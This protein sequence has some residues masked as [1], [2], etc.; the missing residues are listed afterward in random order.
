MLF[1]STVSMIKERLFRG[2]R[3]VLVLL[4]LAVCGTTA[5]AQQNLPRVVFLPLENLAGEQYERD[6]RTIGELLASFINETRRVNVI[7]RMAL[8]AAMAARRFRVEDWENISKTA[9]MGRALNATYIVRGSVSLLGENLIVSARL[10]DIAS[11]ET[12]SFINMQLEALS[13]AYFKMN[14][15]AQL[16][17]NNLE[18]PE[19]PPSAPPPV[20]KE[21]PPVPPPPSEEPPPIAEEASPVPLPL[22]EL[23]APDAGRVAR[24]NTLGVST[25]TVV[26]DPLIII[27]VRGTFAPL[28][29][30]FLEAGCDFGFLSRN[31]KVVKYFSAYP[32]V[33]AEFFLPFA[34]T[35]GAITSGW[36]IG[37][38]GGYMFGKY[39]SYNSY[40]SYDENTGEYTGVPTETLLGIFTADFITGF[41]FAGFC[42]I[43]YTL[44]TDFASVSSK[45]SIGYTYRFK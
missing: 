15:L 34:D 17:T 7:D 28:R 39:T 21:L 36:Y 3:T 43:S 41:N 32:F 4:L 19:Q 9:E 24:L 1:D 11:T 27:T 6:V 2:K 23:A 18:I 44:R 13:E 5:F 25:G 33:H 26:S 38:G 16:L 14:G 42:D 37:A 31:V 29:N 40:D 8:E 20:V 22:P 12:V 30:L 35:S 10:L 45:L